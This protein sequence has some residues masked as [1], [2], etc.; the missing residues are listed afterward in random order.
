MIISAAVTTHIR[1]HMQQ[2]RDTPDLQFAF[3]WEINFTG[4]LCCVRWCVR[5]CAHVPTN[6]RCMC[7]CTYA[8]DELDIKTVVDL[9]PRVSFTGTPL[10]QLIHLVVQVVLTRARGRSSAGRAGV[11]KGHLPALQNARIAERPARCPGNHICI[12]LQLRKMHTFNESSVATVQKT[13]QSLLLFG[14]TIRKD[15]KI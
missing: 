5:V 8:T 9:V 4:T 2:H 14:A 3:I 6:D 1:T 10:P 15:K 13:A 11:A 12:C 7:V